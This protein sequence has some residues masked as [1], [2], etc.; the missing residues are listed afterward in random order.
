MFTHDQTTLTMGTHEITDFAE[1]GVEAEQVGESTTYKNGLAGA[2]TMVTNKNRTYKI[3][4]NLL[5]D[6]DANAYLHA[7]H[8][9]SVETGAEFPLD[10]YI[11]S[12]GE[13]I[14]SGFAA[15][16]KQP[17]MGSKKEATDKAWEITARRCVVTH[18]QDSGSIA[19]ALNDAKNT[20]MSFLS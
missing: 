19:V 15:V 20:L 9:A 2:A 1:G 7:Y 18:D 10:L 13:R 4:A 14:T 8:T 12:T 16:T 5:Q 3:T 17:K 11:A 6:S